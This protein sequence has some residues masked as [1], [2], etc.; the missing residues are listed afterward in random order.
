MK[1]SKIL[2]LVC[3]VACVSCMIWAQGALPDRVPSYFDFKGNPDSWQ[4]KPK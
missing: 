4:N 3:F 1:I 2:W